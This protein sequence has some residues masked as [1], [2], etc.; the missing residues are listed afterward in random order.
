[1]APA[2]HAKGIAATNLV[3]LINSSPAGKKKAAEKKRKEA[4]RKA[5]NAAKK[6]EKIEAAKA[7]KASK[8]TAEKEQSTNYSN[9]KETVILLKQSNTQIAFNANKAEHY[10]DLL[11]AINHKK[12][13]NAV[14]LV[15]A[16]I[17][18]YTSYV[19]TLHTGRTEFLNSATPTK[20]KKKATILDPNTFISS[21]EY[22]LSDFCTR[23][24]LMPLPAP[25]FH[26]SG[27]P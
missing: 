10:S 3:D 13:A 23:S 2:T 24:P 7:K 26:L 16:K 18:R 11:L 9:D 5:S 12:H 22:S 15:K 25:F 4:E 21:S 19:D 1:M 8:K 27:T 14:P 6:A 17:D 20:G